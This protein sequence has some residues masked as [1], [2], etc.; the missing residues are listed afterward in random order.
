MALAVPRDDGGNRSLINVYAAGVCWVGTYRFSSF[1]REAKKRNPGTEQQQRDK[2]LREGKLSL[3]S[4]R[5]GE[6]LTTLLRS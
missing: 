3:D 1:A 2:R 6:V 5:S 4:E